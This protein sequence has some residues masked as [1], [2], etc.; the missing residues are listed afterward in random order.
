MKTGITHQARERLYLETR[1]LYSACGV[2]DPRKII[3]DLAG[4]L[5]PPSGF[6]KSRPRARLE[7][8]FATQGLGLCNMAR[9]Q[10][11]HR[12]FNTWGEYPE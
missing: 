3:A 6:F 10:A 8:F 2:N 11:R 12:Y 4:I 1:S 7:K 9:Q 5:D